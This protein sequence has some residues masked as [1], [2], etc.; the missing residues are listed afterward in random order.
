MRKAGHR[1]RDPIESVLRKP[2]IVV[3]QGL[4]ELRYL[5]LTQGLSNDPEKDFC[6]Y[7]PY[8]WGI[9]LKVPPIQS[10]DYLALIHRGAS[11]AYSK[12][13]NDTFRTLTTDILFQ[14][15]VSETSLIRIL[16]ALAWKHNVSVSE[17]YVQGLNVLAAPF[18]YA[19]GSETQAFAL[20]DTYIHGCCPLYVKP[21]LEGVHLGLKL[22]DT[23][24]KIIDPTLFSY[25][26]RKLLTAELYG[27]A[28]VLTF[29]ACT[30]PLNEVL[31]L[32]D[33]LIAFGPHMNIL[34]VVAQL[35]LIR[36]SIL[37]SQSPMT[38]L[39]TFPPLQAK[40]VIT[41][42]VSFVSKLPEELY[43][44]LVR[45]TYDETVSDKIKTL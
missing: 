7:R 26:K 19:C 21:M 24:L 42:A 34:A 2:H 10:K 33:F 36:D 43:D 14:R 9:L 18:L 28:S 30:P 44:L 39:R 4:S 40:N 12:I 6:S 22:L 31:I 38:L 8:V 17:L 25:L 1:R 11:P 20:F 5:I 3:E 23:S 13:R 29:S 32:W 27:F 45:H 16:N 41:L 37:A 35:L 15:R